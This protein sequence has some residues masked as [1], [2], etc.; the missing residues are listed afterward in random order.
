MNIEPSAADQKEDGYFLATDFD[1]G[2]G[3]FIAVIG[4]MGVIVCDVELCDT[5]QECID[6]YSKQIATKPWDNDSEITKA[7]F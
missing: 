2:R 7:Q 3:K 4:Q 5:Q 6:W 1:H